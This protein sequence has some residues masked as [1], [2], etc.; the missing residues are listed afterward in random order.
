VRVRTLT[1][2]TAP[3]ANTIL[4]RDYVQAIYTGGSARGIIPAFD[5]A[6]DVNHDGYLN[7]A[8]YARR[9]PGKDARF[10]YES[11]LFYPYYGQMRFVTN[12]DGIDVRQ[13]AADYQYRYLQ[14]NALADGIFVDNSAGLLP[15]AGYQTVESTANYS[16]D[17]GAMLG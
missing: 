17:Y 13:W 11:R 15:L 8:E 12:P 2:G 9:A 5:D 6:A 7:N 4:G 16:A 3:V 10:I 1:G 14:A